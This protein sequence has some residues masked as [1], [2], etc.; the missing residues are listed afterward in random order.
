MNKTSLVYSKTEDN[1]DLEVNN[2]VADCHL[3]GN[4]IGESEVEKRYLEVIDNFVC[5][6]ANQHQNMLLIAGNFTESVT[7]SHTK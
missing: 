1:Y 7:S 2:S 4:E 5:Y 3:D 6:V